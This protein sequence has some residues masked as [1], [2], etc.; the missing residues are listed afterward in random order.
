MFSRLIAAWAAL[1]SEDLPIPRAPHRSALLAGKPRAKRWV[2]STRRSRTRSMPRRSERST[3]LTRA[4][5]AR[6]PRSARQIESLGRLE[7]GT[8]RGRGRVALKRLGDT[9]EEVGLA[10]ERRQGESDL[11]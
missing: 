6:S 2:F 3:R 1:T 9:A 11:N 5:G 4:I 10:F 8:R 7:V